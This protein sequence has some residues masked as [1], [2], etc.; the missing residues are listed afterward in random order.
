M[1]E[2]REHVQ[3]NKEQLS[4]IKIYLDAYP[5]KNVNENETEASHTLILRSE[6]NNLILVLLKSYYDNQ[7]DSLQEI[8]MMTILEKT[9]SNAAF[10]YLSQIRLLIKSTF[11]LTG[12]Y[13]YLEAFFWSLFGV[14]VSLIYY[15][16]IAN[17]KSQETQTTEGI[18]SFDPNEVPGHI[19]KMLYAPACTIVL[20]L[21]YHFISG[22]NENMVDISVNKGLIVFS[23]ICGFYS[24]RVMKFM[25]R[26]KDLLL[27]ISSKDDNVK[28]TEPAFGSIDVT[29]KLSSTF[30]D[31]ELAADIIEAGFN[32]ADVKLIS[33]I[34]GKEP[35][36]LLLPEDDQ[37]VSFSASN[38]PA[39][40]YNL[41]ATLLHRKSDDNIINLIGSKSIE[42]SSTKLELELELNLTEAVG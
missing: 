12:K 38:I 20:I 40:E 13:V 18:R 1:N 16:S 33:P 6:R 19:A 36:L 14:L 35:I 42:I 3:L 25:D 8:Q 23:F 24:G 7:L 26:L 17:S 22:V 21:G 4:T 29:L 10:N 2:G 37:A 27:P 15:V 34:E 41:V 11:W 39:G 5:D 32:S 9:T 28:S 30:P 31:K